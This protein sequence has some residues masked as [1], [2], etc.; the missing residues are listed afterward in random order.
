M[1]V[2]MV[3]PHSGTCLGVLDVLSA[4]T[5]TAAVAEHPVMRGAGQV[6]HGCVRAF[7][8]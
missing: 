2:V 6:K 7:A 4:K 8:F 5:T 1:A 3:N